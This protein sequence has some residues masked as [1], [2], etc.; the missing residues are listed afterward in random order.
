M[1]LKSIFLS[2]NWLKYRLKHGEFRNEIKL[3]GHQATFRVI[4]F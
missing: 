2:E 3:V 4:D 1:K